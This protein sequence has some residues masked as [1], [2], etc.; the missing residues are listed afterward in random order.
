L[1][2]CTASI[3]RDACSLFIQFIVWPWRLRQYFLPKLQQ[4]Y[5]RLHGVTSQK[6]VLFIVTTM[7]TS[8]VRMEQLSALC[9]VA[10]KVT[11]YWILFLIAV[12]QEDI[13]NM[14]TTTIH[15]AALFCYKCIQCMQLMVL[16]KCKRTN[17]DPKTSSNLMPT[18]YACCSPYSH[19]W[20][21]GDQVVMV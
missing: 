21:S 7:R 20:G 9:N 15:T 1:E 2:E 5:T 6:V 17:A 4:T 10:C 14:R 18:S 16:S 11:I 12:I 8:D 3:F 13:G 19:I